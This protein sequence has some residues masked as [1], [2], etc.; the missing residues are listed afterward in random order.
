M[1]APE[2]L[3]ELESMTYGARVRRMVELGRRSRDDVQISEVLDHLERGGFYEHLLALQSCF[4]SYDSAR[5]LR[6]VSA[7]SR[8]LHALAVRLL[9]LTCDDGQVVAAFDSMA[10]A[11]RRALVKALRRRGRGA[12]IDMLLGALAAR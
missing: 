10:S 3:H 6:A 2:L 1:R 9:P 7:P 4:G 11:Q 5:V 8:M 12:T